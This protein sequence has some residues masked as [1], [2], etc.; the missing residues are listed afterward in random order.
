MPES[1]IYLP[2]GDPDDKEVISF[3][4]LELLK[5]RAVGEK[6]H[7][8]RREVLLTLAKNSRENGDIFEFIKERAVEDSH[9]SVRKVALQELA[10]FWHENPETLPF[11]R[12]RATEDCNYEVRRAAVK[13]LAENWKHLPEIPELLRYWAENAEINS[14]G[15]HLSRSFPDAGVKTVAALILLQI[16]L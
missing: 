3:R 11:L 6:N 1:I 9:Y 7:T 13:E 16:G 2:P 15:V 12:E 8:D 14:S 4:S 10:R 5:A